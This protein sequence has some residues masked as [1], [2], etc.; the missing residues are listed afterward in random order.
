MSTASFFFLCF[1]GVETKLIFVISMSDLF[2]A[3]VHDSQE[4]RQRERLHKGEIVTAGFMPRCG[5]LF[6]QGGYLLMT[7]FSGYHRRSLALVVG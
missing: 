3:G 4:H 1:I 5:L 2:Q 7:F 6:Q